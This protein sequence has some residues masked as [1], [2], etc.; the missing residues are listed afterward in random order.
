MLSNMQ[1]NKNWETLNEKSFF[2]KFKEKCY[3]KWENNIPPIGNSSS[4]SIQPDTK[5][6][7]GYSTK[8]IMELEQII[9]KKLPNDVQSL[10]ELTKGLSK[11]LWCRRWVDDYKTEVFEI[12][13]WHLTIE[14]L[15]ENYQ[16]ELAFHDENK[17]W[18]ILKQDFGVDNKNNNFYL[19]PIYS[20]RYILCDENS[21]NSSI[22]FSIY[23]DDIIIYGDTIWKYL[24]A[25][26]GVLVKIN[27]S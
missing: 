19:L 2:S 6:L 12:N 3:Q 26:F 22:V 13:N 21:K 5:W 27:F 14:N 11:K 17:T 4:C 1:N 20:H 15:K 23:D 7:D 8:E 16:K 24:Q 9:V 10:L 18:E 25:E